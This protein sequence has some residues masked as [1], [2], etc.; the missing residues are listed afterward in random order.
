ME[1]WL[2]EQFGS[3]WG[4]IIQSAAILLIAY[5]IGLFIRSRVLTWL[6][7]LAEKTTWNWDDPIV[8]NLRSPIVV[9]CLLG[10]VYAVKLRWEKELPPH[11]VPVIH[12]AIIVLLGLSILFFLARMATDLIGLYGKRLALPGTGLTQTVAKGLVLLLGGLVILGS[13]GISITPLI[14]TL[15]IG[16]LAVALALQETLANLF[17]GLFVTMARNMTPGDF[18][19]L[20]SGQEGI[21]ADIGW[22][23]SVVKQLGGGIVIIPNS[24]LAN[25]VITNLHLPEREIGV[26]VQVGVHYRSE[27]DHVEKVTVEV[28]RDCQKTVEGAVPTFEPFIRYHTLGDSKIDFTVILRVK[29]FTANYLLKHEFIRRLHRRYAEE[30][31]VIPYPIRALNLE[32]EGAEALPA[33]KQENEKEEQERGTMEPE[34]N[35]NPGK[36]E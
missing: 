1:E 33:E 8:K 32:Q 21:L 12:K 27:L 23:A 19:K 9:W 7:R 13:L 18:I 4:E 5:G 16:G 30:G 25:S 10:G 36:R 20:E 28:A 26:L 2:I 15:G 14:T 31:I 35:A 3:P 29:E 6:H 34:K 22:R 11:F 17:S 24:K